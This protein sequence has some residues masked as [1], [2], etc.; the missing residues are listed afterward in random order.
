MRDLISSGASYGALLLS[1]LVI[2]AACNRPA[3]VH[4]NQVGACDAGTH[5]ALV[6]FEIRRVENNSGQE[7]TFVPPRVRLEADMLETAP[8]PGYESLTTEMLVGQ[9][10]AARKVTLASGKTALP[11]TYMVFRRQ[12]ADPDGS[13]AANNASYFL[14]YE[15]D[16][17]GPSVFI[18]KDNATQTSWRD[19]SNCGDISTPQ[20]SC[21][22]CHTS[23]VAIYRSKA[24]DRSQMK[25]PEPNSPNMPTH[26]PTSTAR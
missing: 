1:F 13:K 7:F 10:K 16:P 3:I 24:L 18:S 22:G 9:N 4:Y 21:T 2:F 12:T 17:A 6:F 25:Q 26:N 14:G 23:D 11:G 19:T 5:R 8:W 15:K 20:Q